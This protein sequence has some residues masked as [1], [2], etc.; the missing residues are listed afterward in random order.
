[1]ATSAQPPSSRPAPANVAPEELSTTQ[2]VGQIASKATL[3]LREEVELARAELSDGARRRSAKDRARRRDATRRARRSAR[4]ARPP[5]PRGVR[6]ALAATPS[7]HR[8]RRRRFRRGRS[9]RQLLGVP[10]QPS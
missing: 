10:P 4:R 7:S 1:M 2:L 9:P 5:P 8:A 6:L 3:L